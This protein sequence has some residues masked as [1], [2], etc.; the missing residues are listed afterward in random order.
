M[1]L[2]DAL[3]TRTTV[4]QYRPDPLPDGAIE[5]SLIAAVAAPNHRMT[6]PWRFTRVG[7]DARRDLA[8]IGVACKRAKAE[9]K[10]EPWDQRQAEKAYAKLMD[11]PE[12]VVVSQVLDPR[13]DV[14][15]EDYAAVACAIQNLQLSLWAEG[16]GSK[17]SSGGVTTAPEVYQ[18]LNI[19]PSAERIVGFV[20]AGYAA[21]SSPPRKPQRKPVDAVC[22]V[23]V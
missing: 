2:Y 9:Y 10:G 22:R 4:N 18:R 12:L 13:P 15:E 14:A 1:D 17:W 20:W 16:I 5:R 8:D 3:T 11:A 23:C 19:D 6:Q 21:A 7:P